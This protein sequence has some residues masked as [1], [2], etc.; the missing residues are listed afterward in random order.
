MTQDIKSLEKKFVKEIGQPAN[1][2]VQ[3]RMFKYITF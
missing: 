2:V 1:C 3:K